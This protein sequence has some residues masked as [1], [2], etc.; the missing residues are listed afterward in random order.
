MTKP[1]LN[2]GGST[3]PHPMGWGPRM[4]KKK[5]GLGVGQYTSNPSTWEAETERPL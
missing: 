3:L 1:T 4:N 5:S 2:V